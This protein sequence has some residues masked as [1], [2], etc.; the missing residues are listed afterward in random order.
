VLAHFGRR[1]IARKAAKPVRLE[2]KQG[3]MIP[4]RSKWSIASG[5]LTI[6]W[7]SVYR[8]FGMDC[9]NGN[10]VGRERIG[11]AQRACRDVEVGARVGNVGRWGWSW[12][13]VWQDDGWLRGWFGRGLLDGCWRIYLWRRRWCWRELVGGLAAIG[14]G[15]IYEAGHDWRI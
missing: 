1:C 5:R 14:L 4:S 8:I 3:S 7:E 2:D 9:L 12:R 11:S 15:N 6:A 13:S 10:G